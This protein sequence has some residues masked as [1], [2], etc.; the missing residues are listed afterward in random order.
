M[1]NLLKFQAKICYTAAGCLIKDDK[2][3]LVKHKKLGI[4]LNPGG[5]IEGNELPHEAAEREFF[6]ETNVKVK[7]APYNLLEQDDITEYLPCPFAT[8]LHWVSRENYDFR[9]EGKER[10]QK[11]QKNWSR[12][13]EQHVSFVYFVEP[14]GSTEFTQDMEETDGIQWFTLEE[15]E[16]LK[17]GLSQNVLREVRHAFEITL[18]S[19]TVKSQK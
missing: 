11:T 2:V 14:I 7:A 3:L 15:L 8:N 10:S 6:E 13:C 5:H 17:E 1:A 4:W 12:G 19:Q 16:Q 9:T 18:S